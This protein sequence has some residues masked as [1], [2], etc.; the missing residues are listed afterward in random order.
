MATFIRNKTNVYSLG[1][2]KEFLSG[3]RLP[4]VGDIL[5]FYLYQLKISTTKHEAAVVT[6]N[7]VK[8]FWD[9]A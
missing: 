2:T 6:L 1:S 7:E 3:T 9:K 8:T 4:P 5:R